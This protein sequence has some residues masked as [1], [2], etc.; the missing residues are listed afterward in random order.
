[1]FRRLR[2]IEQVL[3]LARRFVRRG[4][5][6]RAFLS[7]VLCLSFLSRSVL[8]CSVCGCDP[9][10]GTLGLD[11][12]STKDLRVAVE[13]R[14]LRKESGTGDGAESD[15][16]GRLLLR[17]QYALAPR[18]VLQAE[19]PWYI[20]KEHLNGFGIRD[21]RATG[22]GDIAVSARAEVLRLGLE[23]RHVLALTG[24]LEL[25]TGPN[26]RRLGE[27]APD[28]H[29]Q[30]G[31]GSWDELLGASYAYG[32]RPWTLFANVTGRMNGS[33]A[34]GFRYGHALFATV[35]ARRALGEVGRYLISLEAQLRSAGKDR[36]SDGSSDEDSGGQILYTTASAA[37]GLTEDL[38]VRAIVQVP[39]LTSL[40]GVQS[41]HPVAYLALSYDWSL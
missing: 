24:T 18:V 22:L 21:D 17:A 13:T 26:D 33:N 9:A 20:W 36:R 1:M 35:G 27:D 5:A 29:L 37:A 4:F 16:E 12:P 39:T 11:R 34:R 10:A 8:A 7:A 41:E 2:T 15:R 40:N 28:E 23:A 3:R 14:Y 38:L 6:L 31:S 30:L 19:V 32:V 25:P